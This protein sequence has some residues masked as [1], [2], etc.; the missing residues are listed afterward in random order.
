MRHS[1]SHHRLTRR[2]PSLQRDNLRCQQAGI[3]LGWASEIALRRSL[4]TGAVLADPAMLARMIA[5]TLAETARQ[6]AASILAEAGDATPSLPPPAPRPSLVDQAVQRLL[7]AAIARRL[8]ARAAQQQTQ[9]AAL[10][11]GGSHE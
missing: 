6:R 2:P 3:L 7:Q 8:Q 11:Q 5:E 4:P 9:L 10:A 1:P